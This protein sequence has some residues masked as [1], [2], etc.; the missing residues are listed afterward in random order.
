MAPELVPHHS[1]SSSLRHVCTTTP[2]ELEPTYLLRLSSLAAPC[3]TSCP[4]PDRAPPWRAW[5]VAPRRL[6]LI[7]APPPPIYPRRVTSLLSA[8]L[9]EC[10]PS[11]SRRQ[12]PVSSEPP[13][14]SH[15]SLLGRAH[16]DLL[17]AMLCTRTWGQPVRLPSS[18]LTPQ[19]PTHR[20]APPA[21]DLLLHCRTSTPIF[22]YLFT[23]MYTYIY[24]F[25][26]ICL[27]MHRNAF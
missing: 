18:S 27:C 4:W 23:Y 11:S 5:P 17:L 7:A 12:P 22:I 2:L 14:S 19:G 13:S 15:R 6:L 25:L 24:C 3:H 9:R 10:G 20:H 1:S 21:C 26:E 8:P 16:P